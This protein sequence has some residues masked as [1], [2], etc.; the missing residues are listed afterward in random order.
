MI[1]HVCFY[2]FVYKKNQLSFKRVKDSCTKKFKKTTKINP[3]HKR[4]VAWQSHGKNFGQYGSS[5]IYNNC[6]LNS[7]QFS[8]FSQ[9]CIKLQYCSLQ[10]MSWFIS[11][12]FNWRLKYW[13]RSSLNR[14]CN[15]NVLL[16]SNVITVIMDKLDR[17][18]DQVILQS[19]HFQTRI[20]VWNM[21]ESH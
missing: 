16:K 9:K 18:L 20:Q 19:S 11:Q 15:L 17:R 2:Q 14:Q 8:C 1:K 12:R 10:N 21:V 13:Q 7:V 5:K 3:P 6:D 4:N